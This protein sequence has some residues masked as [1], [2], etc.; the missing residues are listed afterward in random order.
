[1]RILC[2][3]ATLLFV[4]SAQAEVTYEIF[5]KNRDSPMSTTYIMGV[6]RGIEWMNSLAK[7]E[8]RPFYCS[9]SQLPL[10]KEQIIDI[11]D[12]SAQK[13]GQEGRKDFVELILVF[14]LRDFFPCPRK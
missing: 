12:R 14:A 9:P 3:L 7:S 4:S 11:L 1:M 2:F 13:R 8:G 10:T 5:D 6:A